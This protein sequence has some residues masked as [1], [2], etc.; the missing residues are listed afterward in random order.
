MTVWT[1]TSRVGEVTE[2]LGLGNGWYRGT[3]SGC[4]GEDGLI[5]VAGGGVRDA[6]AYVHVSS[7]QITY[8]ANNPLWPWE[9][10]HYGCLSGAEAA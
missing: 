7:G 3:A 5:S 2:D 10:R 1:S 9:F 6:E 8:S 4:W